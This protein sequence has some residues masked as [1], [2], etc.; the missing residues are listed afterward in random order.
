[1][2]DLIK[3]HKKIPPSINLV[4]RLFEI[5]EKAKSVIARGD[6][7]DILKNRNQTLAFNM[8]TVKMEMMEELSKNETNINYI[9]YIFA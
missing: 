1:M 9:E 8:N 3:T 4:N 5:E 2:G 6:I 7:E